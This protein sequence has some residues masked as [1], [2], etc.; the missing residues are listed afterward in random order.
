M[1]CMKQLL[2]GALLA[3]SLLTS[4][5]NDSVEDDNIQIDTKPLNVSDTECLKEYGKGCEVYKEGDT[6]EKEGM[7]ITVNSSRITKQKGDWE[8]LADYYPDEDENGKVTDK[9]CY[10]IVNLT[11]HVKDRKDHILGFC[12]FKAGVLN[13]ETGQSIQNSSIVSS[14]YYNDL[15]ETKRESDDIFVDYPKEGED[16]VNQ[17]FIFQLEDEDYIKNENIFYFLVEENTATIEYDQGKE[18][19]ALVKLEPQI[20]L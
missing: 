20:D 8:N 19:V 3:A 14:T 9:S 6:F 4:C 17:D 15:S 11:I 1:K 16:I 7:E 13:K 18:H 2:V 12:G 10:Y 5:K